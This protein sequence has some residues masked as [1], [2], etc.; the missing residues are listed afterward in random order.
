MPKGVDGGIICLEK[1]YK[2]WMNS[3]LYLTWQIFAEKIIFINEN[4]TE[5]SVN[6]S[7][8]KRFFNVSTFFSSSSAFI[9][10]Q[11]RMAGIPLRKRNVYSFYI[12]FFIQFTNLY[13]N[14]QNVALQTLSIM[15]VT[16][17]P[18]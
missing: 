14:K 9:K 11:N 1:N 5:I 3:H 7:R 12:L 16:V 18:K 10:I 2:V 8:V 15:F 17:P 4:Y 13:T 6:C